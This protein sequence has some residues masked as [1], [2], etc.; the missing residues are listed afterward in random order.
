[1]ARMAGWL[2]RDI[3]IHEQ[4]LDLVYRQRKVNFSPNS[5]YKYS[6]TGTLL[7]AEI[8]NR[9]SGQTFAEF[10]KEKVFIPLGMR[11]T[12]VRDDERKII[13]NLAKSYYWYDH[14]LK[15]GTSPYESY[16]STNVYST[17][18]DLAKWLLHMKRPLVGTLEMFNRMDTPTVIEDGT[19]IH[20]AMG[21]FVTP[22]RGIS[23][24]E[25][26]GGHIFVSYLGRFKELDLGIALS[27]NNS[28]YNLRG[29]V[30]QIADLFIKNREDEDESEGVILEPNEID[31]S[32]KELAFFQGSYWS[33]E[34]KIVRRIIARNDTLV[35]WRSENNESYFKP[36]AQNMFQMLGE[37]ERITL[38]FEKGQMI[39]D[40]STLFEK[41]TSIGFND[42]NAQEYEGLY[43]SDELG[44]SY[45]LQV[46]EGKIF[47]KNPK[48][49]L[50]SLKPIMKD[51]FE[52]DKWFLNLFEF[53]RD[54]RGE[55]LGFSA[56]NYSVTDVWFEK[57]K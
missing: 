15:E 32:A 42:M 17:P 41:F 25:H 8:V 23:Q 35:Y 24:V 44:Q 28:D 22:Y 45:E 30:H 26:T 33:K 3:V 37:T 12:F 27:S 52:S 20:H 13:K 39:F 16:G 57:V 48:M 49:E 55:I 14:M 50:I 21:Q 43:F 46:L 6:N 2:P 5:D 4:M 31:L 18:E 34:D 38:K 9:I 29:T 51:R 1:M 7:L 11:Q 54:S 10:L 56:S 47:G 53:S 19:E 40:G 36:I